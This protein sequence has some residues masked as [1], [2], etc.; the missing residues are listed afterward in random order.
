MMALIKFT[1]ASYHFHHKHDKFLCPNYNV[2]LKYFPILLPLRMYIT[3]LVHPPGL[4]IP[5]LLASRYT[6]VSDMLYYA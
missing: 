1:E 6:M 3:G 2:M 4:C 5:I